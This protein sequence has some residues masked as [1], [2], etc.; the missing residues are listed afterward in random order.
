[1]ARE[2]R[3]LR[4]RGVRASRASL[5]QALAR[6]GL[7]TQ[8]ALA[9]R[10]A[11]REGLDIPPRDLVSR[12]FREK[13]VDPLSLERVARALEVEAHTLYLSSTEVSTYSDPAVEPTSGLASP[14]KR[15]IFTPWRVAGGMLVILLIVIG[16][17]WN[18]PAT[19]PL[20]CGISEFLHP[21]RV[22]KGR[23]GIVIARFANDPANAGQYFLA[24]NFISDP[25]LDPYVSVLTT[26]HVLSLDG[27]GDFGLRRNSVREQG[28]ELLR[29]IGARIL[30]WGRVEGNRIEV[31]FISSRQGSTPVT[32]EIG[33]RPVPVEE[34]RLQIPLLLSQSADS[35]PDIK[36]TALELMSLQ[37]PKETQLRTQAMRS[38]TSSID[39]LRASI[40]GSE[41]LRRSINPRLDPQR[42]A[43][44]NSDLCYN[45]R[46]LGEYD[47][48]VAEFHS[49][50]TACN[51]V[52][53][54]RPKA[55][56]PRDWAQ[57]EINLASV[58][59]RLH[60]FAA[61]RED[62]IK[63]LRKAET[64]LLAADTIVQRP[65]APQLWA[66]VQRNLGIVYIRLGELAT[67]GESERLFNKAI[68]LTKT[69][70]E[71]QNPAFQPLDWA[72]TQQNICL[73]QHE[74][75]AHHGTA[76]IEQVKEAI[77][78]CREALRWLSP[79]QS[80]LD[81]AMV[82][83]N[84]AISEA[85]LAQLQTDKP[86]LEAAIGA[87]KQ[88]QTVYTKKDL[89]VKWAMVET[90]LGELYCHTA[91]LEHDRAAFEQAVAHTGEA[92]EVF[93]IRKISRYRHYTERQIAA[94]K[95]C[96]AGNG[97]LC[98]C[99]GG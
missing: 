97:S 30:L 67:D 6:A 43:A 53:K 13:P 27:S 92:L 61:N 98:T 59:V 3:R 1:M 48:N 41:N 82:Q 70:L 8:S 79:E 86:N 69:S 33:G 66:I 28:R 74:L 14:R 40:V 16:V 80:A 26:C 54:V 22:A 52:L 31:R 90:N 68:T 49:A 56:Y 65:F 32:I 18:L 71:V 62:S 76:G 24:N 20:G 12:V 46:L 64:S 60:L 34:R 73:A 95:A 85:M 23:L 44:V 81:W 84:L 58:Y 96:A 55:Q 99:D 57:A 77:G 47:E 39:W 36:K 21:P 37:T 10:M 5:S 72:I 42:W 17:F 93:T 19:T 25:R 94:V 35:L 88:A 9:E 51:N 50:E 91:R 78:H 83:N 4:K 87:F 29:R 75:G 11:D 63:L 2:D 89:P 7:K 15:R 38:Y 45:Y